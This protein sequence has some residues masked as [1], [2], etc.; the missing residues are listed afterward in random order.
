MMSLK[1]GVLMREYRHLSLEEREKLYALREQGI[2]LRQIGKKLRRSQSSLT[3]ELQRNIRY[4]N[5]Y[6]GNTYLPCKAQTLADKRGR[7]QRT[8]AP[9]KSPAIFLYV[10]EHLRRGWSPE[11]IAGRIGIDHQGLSIC[12]ETI[13]HYIYAKNRYVRGL[14][15]EQYLILKRKKRM[16]KEGR[17][18]H[19]MSRIPEAISIEKRPK[20]VGRRKQ[21]GHWETDNVIGKQTD[22]SALSVTVERVTRATLLNKLI[23]KTAAVKTAAVV[24]RLQALPKT[25]RKTLT[26]DN[27]AE[28]TNHYDITNRTHM[29]VYFCHAYH[30]WEKGTVENMNGRIRRFIPKGV[31]IDSLTDAYIAQLEEQLNSTPRKCL[32]YLTPYEMMHKLQ[33]TTTQ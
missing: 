22:Q 17:T 10:R 23:N 24:N 8:K 20:I 4:G 26:A 31:S 13:Y 12:H 19:R 1:G 11:T 28:N 32:H 6:F 14:H 9:L 2:S 5:E 15:L 33:S 25:Y 29:L 16:K 27:G 3:R 7:I 30:S 21:I 18:V